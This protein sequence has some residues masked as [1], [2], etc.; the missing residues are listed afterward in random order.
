LMLKSPS[1][2]KY[3]SGKSLSIKFVRLLC[4]V[5]ASL[6]LLYFL[7]TFPARGFQTPSTQSLD[8][9]NSSEQYIQ[10]NVF[11]D[12]V[13]NP[14]GIGRTVRF[15]MLITPPP[16]TSNDRFDGVT[17]SITRP[18]GTTY[19]RGT[20]FS[21]SNGLLYT[22]YVPVLVGNYSIQMNYP[23]QLF[24]SRNLTYVGSQSPVI[25]LSVK[26]QASPKTWIVD[27]D[28]PADFQTIQG[29]I[30]AASSGDTIFVRSGMYQENPVVNKSL[31]LIGEGAHQTTISGKTSGKI[32]TVSASRVTI[33]GFRIQGIGGTQPQPYDI[34]VFFVNLVTYSNISHNIITGHGYGISLR[35]SQHSV[36]SNYVVNNTI[37]GIYLNGSSNNAITRNNVTGGKTGI[38]ISWPSSNNILRSNI[39]TGENLNLHVISYDI[40]GFTNDIDTSNTIN[41]RPVYYWINKAN[42]IVPAG[43]GAVYLIN[44]VNITVQDLEISSNGQ[45]VLLA[46]TKGSTVQRNNITKCDNGIRVQSSSNNTLHGN[47]ISYGAFGIV[48]YS[49]SA[50]RVTNNSIIGSSM[51]GISLMS[52]SSGNQIYHNSLSNKNQSRADSL[53]NTW[54]NG[55]PSGGNYW[56]DYNGTDAN[57][58]GIG[59]TPYIISANNT[60][61]YPLVRTTLVKSNVSTS[62]A[63]TQSSTTTSA[64]SKEG[65]TSTSQPKENE[66]KF[67]EETTPIDEEPTSTPE[68]GQQPFTAPDYP[69][70]AAIIPIALLLGVATAIA[71]GG[72]LLLLRRKR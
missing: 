58:D 23:G 21:D 62:N 20:F 32:V 49:S 38:F 35:G 6:L 11:L 27:D 33:T 2:K 26:L 31:S 25:T 30:N 12:L 29:A 60:D 34:G 44:S 65:K 3:H 53:A 14:V 13:P 5:S 64:A 57:G 17:L 48:L 55:Y 40:P 63:T 45:G 7:G 54:D 24:A 61:R 1:F 70:S 22:D 18:D 9:E 68:D 72:P 28:M 69:L 41:G 46:Y 15:N 51:Q 71:F 47:N 52:S 39:M 16:P 4:V 19:T 37:S 42:Q 10:P 36:E 43:A 8:L 66:S 67:Y 50:N 56:S 59:E